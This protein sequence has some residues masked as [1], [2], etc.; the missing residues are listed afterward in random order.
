M[1]AGSLFQTMHK[2]LIPD[3]TKNPISPST[4][5]FYY[6]TKELS[7][8][9]MIC[10]LIA[11]AGQNKGAGPEEE[12][13]RRCGREL[14]HALLN[15]KRE[16]KP[17]ELPEEIT[18]E[19][20]QQEKGIDVLARINKKHV[21]LIEDKTSSRDHSG[22]LKRYYGHVAGGLSE[23]GE[24]AAED[25]YPIYFKTGNQPRADDRR[26]ERFIEGAN[27]YRVF[28]RKDFLRVLNGYKGKNQILVDFRR[29]LQNWEDE[30][31]GY[32]DWSKESPKSGSV[33]AWRAWQGFF[34]CLE[35]ELENA[36]WEDV[37]NPSGGFLGF[38]WDPSGDW[39]IYLQI[40][41][42]EKLCFRVDSEG[43][44]DK[45]RFRED[46]HE[47]IMQAGNHHKQQV[48]R[49][50]MG[51]GKTMTVGVWKEDWMAFGQDGKLDIPGTV[52]NLKQA[53]SVLRAA[54][55]SE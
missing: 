9:A 44:E 49:P 36:R 20:L 47:R 13:L 29:Y 50:K 54:A 14:V 38:W 42:E 8:D 7:Q 11:W 41:G 26:I 25:I 32:K 23:L 40:E 5:L 24:T 37:H 55:N 17:V 33:E 45:P 46:W 35:D 1:N 19:I 12:E 43:E 28:H 51:T 3:M 48:V 52:N 39:T 53:E 15:H 2:N 27:G 22:Q 18:T 16:G 34:L 30:T 10:W 21:L 6:A 31:N 4:N